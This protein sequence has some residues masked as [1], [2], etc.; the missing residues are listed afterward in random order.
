MVQKQIHPRCLKQWR[1]LV[2]C[3]SSG[4]IKKQNGMICLHYLQKGFKVGLGDVAP[5]FETI[6]KGLQSIKESLL[7]IFSGPAGSGGCKYLGK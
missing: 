7:G 3:K 4:C 2:L 1:Y 5:R 6:K